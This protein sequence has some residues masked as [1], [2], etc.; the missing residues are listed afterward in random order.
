VFLEV[1]RP[2]WRLEGP[3]IADLLE[4]VPDPQ[5]ARLVFPTHETI[6]R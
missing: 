6:G 5:D 4:V 2:S 3:D 1:D